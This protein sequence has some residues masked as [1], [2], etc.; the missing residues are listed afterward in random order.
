MYLH[1]KIGS[2]DISD[3]EIIKKIANKN[4]PVFVATGASTEK[5]VRFSC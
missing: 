2:G 1:I 3:H 5:E 4:K